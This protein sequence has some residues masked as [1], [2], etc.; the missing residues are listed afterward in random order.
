MTVLQNFSFFGCRSLVSVSFPASLPSLGFNSFSSCL[1]LSSVRLPPLL[2]STGSEAF[3]DCPSLRV[4]LSSALSLPSFKASSGC[5]FNCGALE[6]V[7][8]PALPSGVGYEIEATAFEGCKA[9]LARADEHK[10]D[11]G[12]FLRARAE[13]RKTR[14]L[15]L[16]VFKQLLREEEEGNRRGEEVGEEEETSKG[17]LKGREAWRVITAQELW[18]EILVFI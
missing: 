15:L 18:R 6:T 5:F 9:L 4:V 10:M 16:C 7:Y 2:R 8:L 1:S 3:Y 12:T 13:A 14:L 17:T 11:V